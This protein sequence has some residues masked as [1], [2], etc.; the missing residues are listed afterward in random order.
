MLPMTQSRSSSPVR[1]GTCS[2]CRREHRRRPVSVS[3]EMRI[4]S[5]HTT[6]IY[7]DKH[8]SRAT[9]DEEVSKYGA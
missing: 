4:E 6:T 8:R 2:A 9:A 3:S 7:H 5:M 1:R